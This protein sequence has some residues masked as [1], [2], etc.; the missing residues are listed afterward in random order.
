MIFIS[1]SAV[2]LCI[3]AVISRFNIISK[4]CIT[5]VST[6]VLIP[7]AI[8]LV[9]IITVTTTKEFVND[10]TRL[11]GHIGSWDGGSITTAIYLLDAGRTATFDNHLGLFSITGRLVGRQVTTAINS[12]HIIAIRIILAIHRIVDSLCSVDNIGL[13]RF[14]QRFLCL[15]TD[16]CSCSFNDICIRFKS[17]SFSHIRDKISHKSYIALI[18]SLICRIGR[19]KGDF[20]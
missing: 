4:L 16:G 15:S 20:S 8:Y 18:L 6:W 3:I 12:R 2:C 1:T 11:H 19:R 7:L 10:I 17:T 9:A 13:V 14:C 5:Y